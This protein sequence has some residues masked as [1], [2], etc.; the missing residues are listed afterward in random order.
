MITGP[1]RYL[2]FIIQADLDTEEVYA[3]M[4]HLKFVVFS[5]VFYLYV[6]IVLL[7]V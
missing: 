1:E 3:Q 5:E 2:L 4:P 6:P 7:L